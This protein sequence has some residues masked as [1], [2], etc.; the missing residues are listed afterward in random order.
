MR[1]FE[2]SKYLESISDTSVVTFD[3]IITVIDIVSTKMT[4]TIARNKSKNFDIKKVRN[5]IIA[6]FFIQFY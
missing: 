5:K 6:I 4:N 1:I 3:E 2:N